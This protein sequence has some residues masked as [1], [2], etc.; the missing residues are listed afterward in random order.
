MI[1]TFGDIAFQVNADKVFTFDDFKKTLKAGFARHR[2]IG[3]KPVIEYTGPDLDTISFSI[4]LDVSLRSVPADEIK[5]L[6]TLLGEGVEKNLI[7]GNTRLGRFVL[8]DLDE[9]WTKVDSQGNLLAA[10]IDLKLLE[11]A[12]G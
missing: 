3:K 11:C 1:G 8:T 4:R 2:V 7:V 12:N 6:E 5:K 9:T 10:I